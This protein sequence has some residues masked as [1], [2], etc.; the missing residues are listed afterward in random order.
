M[1]DQDYFAQFKPHTPDSTIVNNSG[2]DD[3]FSQFKPHTESTNII[4]GYNVD[5][6]DPVEGHQQ[7]TDVNQ[8][9]ALGMD[10][11]KAK[12]ILSRNI[13][14]TEPTQRGTI[15]SASSYG[16]GFMRSVLNGDA[17]KANL[18]S[19]KGYLKGGIAELPE[20]AINFINSVL[21]GPTQEKLSNIPSDIVNLPSGIVDTAKQMY[22]TT[23]ESGSN[24]EA[25][26]RMMGQTTLQPLLTEGLVKGV[27]PVVKGTVPPIVRGAGAVTQKTGQLM[28]DY[29]PLS[30]ATGA[31][32]GAK[33]GGLAGAIIG[34]S[35]PL[36]E[37]YVMLN[38]LWVVELKMLVL[39][40]VNL[41]NLEK[42]QL[43]LQ[44]Q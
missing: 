1:P 5:T 10:R 12:S 21:E 43:K 16:T 3:Y 41:T 11:E 9:I 7:L 18:N 19:L 40:C 4:G 30:Y 13:P 22:K 8:L 31:I 42:F 15:P 25:F 36:N 28:Q 35:K 17:I 38:Q 14:V 6:G 44:Q 29:T 24:P 37:Y 32:A 39:K 33:T 27:P 23:M 2:G 34:T 20:N 26:G